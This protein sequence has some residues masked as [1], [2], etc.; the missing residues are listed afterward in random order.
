MQT[1]VY[2]GTSGYSYSDW[3][4]PVYPLGT[5]RTRYLEVYAQTFSSVELNFSYYRQ[6]NAS[7]IERMIE[8]TSAD[9]RFSIKAHKS[10]THVVADEWKRETRTFLEGIRP[11]VELNRLVAVLLQFPF[12]FH[13]TRPNRVYLDR[14]CGS[15][16]SVPIAIEFRNAEWHTDHVFGELSKRGISYAAA[17]YPALDG[18]PPAKAVATSEIGYVRFHGR[19]REN[20]WT[21]T[22]ESRY[23][24]LYSDEEIEEWIE[25]IRA[26]ASR[27][28]ILLAVFNNHW[29]GQAVSNALTFKK[30][31]EAF[32]DL[33]LAVPH[34]E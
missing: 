18:L 5:D 11:L 16:A 24:Y 27:T 22:N 15:L 9:F 14:L 19:N 7:T 8:R 33:E 32:N 21:G 3:V 10:L 6:P 17:D 20:W 12:S 34:P 13:Y 26:I 29:R 30:K 28:R 4:G 23:D 25:R 2:I 1:R 31:L